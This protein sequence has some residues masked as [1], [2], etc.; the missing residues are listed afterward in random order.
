[1]ISLNL[2][3]VGLAIPSAAILISVAQEHGFFKSRG[4]NV[5]PVLVSGTNVPLLTDDNPVGL[6]GA[7]AALLRAAEGDDLKIVGVFNTSRISGRLIAKPVFNTVQHLRGARAG[8]RAFGAGQWIQT[9]V[10]LEHLGLYPARDDIRLV[11]VGDEARI[12]RAMQAG[13]IDAAVL[14][15]VQSQKLEAH[16]FEVLLDIF[17]A[18]I[19][20]FT[21]ALTVKSTLLQSSP[22]VIARLVG[23][24]MDCV[25]FSTAPLNKTSILRTIGKTFS[26][27]D[28]TAMRSGYEEFMMTVARVPYPSLSDLLTMQSVMARHDATVLAVNIEHLIE[29]RFVRS[30]NLSLR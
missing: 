25:D 12:A 24:F 29:D 15:A 5:R 14:S 16:G 6:I 8:V 27:R 10:V 26:V 9:V 13:E 28:A 7:P 21:N 23:A 22:D 1:M 20:G 19:L 3:H 11:E 17:P 18:N 4:L 2:L 30:E